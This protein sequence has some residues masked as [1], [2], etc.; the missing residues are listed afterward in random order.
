M[1]DDFLGLSYP[2]RFQLSA[3]DGATLTVYVPAPGSVTLIAARS[4]IVGEPHE[5]GVLC[6]Y[7]GW[8][9]GPM[10]YAHL[11]ARGLWEAGVKHA[12][13]RA[14]VDYPT[15]ARRLV[16]LDDLVE[17]GTIGAADNVVSVTNEP[18]VQAWLGQ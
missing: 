7:E 5:H 2:E 17:V 1:R 18:A 10:Q 4:G 16:D 9:N 8:V 3:R 11:D 14:F 13:G 6:H 12:A 15:V